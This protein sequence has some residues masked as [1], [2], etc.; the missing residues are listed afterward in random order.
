MDLKGAQLRN[1]FGITDDIGSVRS[2]YPKT[3][4]IPH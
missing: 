2:E 1:Y 3:I 4:K